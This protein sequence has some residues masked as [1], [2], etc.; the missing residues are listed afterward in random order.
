[1]SSI[2]DIYKKIK[3]IGK[4]QSVPKFRVRGTA[5]EILKHFQQFYKLMRKK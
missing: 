1:M 4:N 3:I 2:I 5:A